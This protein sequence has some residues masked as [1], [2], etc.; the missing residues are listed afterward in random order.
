MF[1]EKEIVNILRL[2]GYKITHQRQAILDAITS[3]HSHL[4]PAAVYNKVKNKYPDIGLVTIYRTIELLTRLGFICEVHSGNNR[5]YLM[6]R[7]SGHHHHLLCS[8]C[9]K[10]IEFTDCELSQME[11]KI[12]CQTDFKIDSHMVEFVGRCH[13]CRLK[14]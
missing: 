1:E 4:T 12:A 3:S 9:K 8:I 2:R 13:D 7:S 5:S 6:R 14:N 11:E 10:V